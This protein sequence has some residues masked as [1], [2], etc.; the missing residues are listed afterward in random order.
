MYSVALVQ[1]QS[2]MS[3][4]SYADA[5]P[6]LDDY[7]FRLFTGDN[8]RDLPSVL[9]SRQADAMLLATNA[10]NDKDILA[11]LCN[12][13][14]A[15]CLERFLASGRGVLSLQ[16]LGLGMRRGPTMRLL[17][18]PLGQVRPAVLDG[19]DDALRSGT[20][21]IGHGAGGHVA[22]TYPAL[23]DPEQVRSHACA[24]S[25]LPG[26]YWHYW[27]NVDVAEWDQLVVDPR[28]QQ[29]RPLVLSAKESRVG[30][31]VI[32]ALPLDWQKHV[33][34]FR[35][36]LM[37][38][39]EGRHT[40]ATVDIR[41]SAEI[42]DYLRETM[43]AQRIPF[44]QYL[45]P[46]DQADLI[47]NIDREVH[48]T[49]LLGVDVSDQ[50][51]PE[52]VVRTLRTAV[53]RGKLRVINV[54]A[55][56]FGTRTMSVISRERRPHRLLQTTELEVQSELRTGYIDDSFWSHVETLQT[57]EQMP[58][59][60]VD[61]GRLQDAAFQITR[62]HD[63]HGS[64]DDVFGATCAY[65]WLRARYLG[66]D[67]R[68]A[69]QTADWIR[70]ELPDHQ[71]HERALAYLELARLGQLTAAEQQDLY[72]ISK[73]LDLDQASETELLQYLRALHAA[74][75]DQHD[76]VAALA[77][78]LVARQRDGVWVDLTTTASTASALLEAHDELIGADDHA[79]VL[80]HIE[81]AARDAVVV[82]LRSLARS[83]A[84]PEPH[85]YPW[86]GKAR[87]TT[88]CLQAWLRFEALQDLPVYEIL[89]SL[90]RA[91]RASTGSVANR[92]ALGVLQAI[93]D[94]NSRQ[95]IELEA[96]QR[97][98]ERARRQQ[99]RM[100]LERWTGAVVLYL[101]GAICIGLLAQENGSLGPALTTAFVDAWSFHVA[102][103][104]LLFTAGVISTFRKRREGTDEPAEGAGS[105]S[106]RSDTA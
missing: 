96:R 22:L 46:E 91:D 28:P 77:S 50:T 72:T 71:P 37:F 61:Y 27:D 49:L 21:A 42:P 19:G 51:L 76:L 35:N 101:L 7:A 106:R 45:I 4:Y 6:L 78:A 82:I 26:L 83:E 24:F 14:F 95:R 29:L 89:E 103:V 15:A 59:R 52:P 93:S 79:V 53:E 57:L 17:P 80:E 67:S 98:V 30:R 74:R 41:G 92:T 88:K 87:T 85:S 56:V 75:G 105:G 54:G 25:G 73:D 40:V 10:L 18:G 63:R 43:R 20:L 16:Q 97:E 62:N 8:I 81:I 100:T 36:L 47:R 32:S 2:E 34:F 84:S 9:D 33:G 65:Y 64:Y 104:G 94:E 5:R 102:V 23:V 70:R 31:V 39:I 12:N 11:S 90:G 69:K 13:E 44:G 58:D 86:D 68:E 3:H 99:E 48:A 60:V 66:V 1:N 55:E 38:V